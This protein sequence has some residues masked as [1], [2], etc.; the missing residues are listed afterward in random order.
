M[1][2]EIWGKNDHNLVPVDDWEQHKVGR[3]SP[4]GLIYA[5]KPG[6]AWK[7]GRIAIS[8]HDLDDAIAHGWVRSARLG[9]WVEVKKGVA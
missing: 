2:D 4:D 8:K 5:S 3:F 1:T 6:H 9:P 7:G